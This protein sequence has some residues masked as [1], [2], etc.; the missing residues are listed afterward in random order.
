MCYFRWCPWT[1]TGALAPG[2]GGLDVVVVAVGG[3]ESQPETPPPPT[4]M[5]YCEDGGVGEGVE[6]G[7]CLLP[8]PTSET[9]SAG[10]GCQP[11]LLSRDL[12]AGW[13]PGTLA[14]RESRERAALSAG[15]PELGARSRAPPLPQPILGPGPATGLCDGSVRGAILM[16]RSLVRRVPVLLI[17]F[18]EAAL[19]SPSERSGFMG[20]V[21]DLNLTGSYFVPSLSL[22]LFF[23]LYFYFIF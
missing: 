21:H 13:F 19:P 12:G 2:R 8:D 4:G 10:D 5:N 22:S 1:D 11:R 15:S 20:F 7:P 17:L 6:G 18:P 23:N 16:R 9:K 14:E 3:K